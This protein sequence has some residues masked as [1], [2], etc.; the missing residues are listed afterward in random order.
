MSLLICPEC[1]IENPLDAEICSACQ[2]RLADV[3]PV[4]P[5]QPQPADQDEKDLLPQADGD[6]KDLQPQADEDEKD[7]L[8]QADEDLPALLHSLKQD[9]DLNGF[10]A[11]ESEDLPPS[12]PEL[13]ELEGDDDA[14]D[15]PDLPEWLHRIRERAQAETDSMGEITQRIRAARESL[16]DDNQETRH[17]AYES[18]IQ[19]IHGEDEEQ[20]AEK[21]VVEET[22][23]EEEA[24][25][26]TK[27][28]GET[29]DTDW[30]TKIRKKLQP[31]SAEEIEAEP[32]GD[33]LFSRDGDSLLQWLVAL[34]EDEARSEEVSPEDSTRLDT[35]GGDT[36]EVEVS[37]ETEAMAT[38]E[39]PVG[40]RGFT[41]EKAPSLTISQEEQN[42]AD[43]LADTISD[44]KAPR[45]LHQ[46]LKGF[47]PWGIRL[48]MGVLLVAVV[49][50]A[51]FLPAPVDFPPALQG[52]HSLAVLEWTQS[53]PQEASLLFVLD[54]QAGFSAE[55]DLI[56]KPV[57]DSLFIDG[58]EI[59]ILASSPSGSLLF[60]RF[61]EET[62]LTDRTEVIDLGYYPVESFGAYGL[63]SQILSEWR[64]ISQPAFTKTLPS[65][66]LDGIIILAD[67]YEGAMAWVEQLSSLVPE[68]PIFLL[69][70]S[71][72]APLL[73]PYWESGQVMGI[74]AGMPDAVNLA[75]ETVTLT[76]RWRAYQAGILLVIVMLLIG[77]TFPVHTKEDEEGRNGQ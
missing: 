5:E 38:Q 20:P 24:P 14:G 8:P 67:D 40:A 35:P 75:G 2:A 22:P 66:P 43:Q 13:G 36:Q 55:L 76:S 45:S 26:A 52:P 30:L 4:V 74:A 70:T 34:E 48:V 41:K 49:C 61:L 16:D 1:G 10:P 60:S 57:L 7:L 15:E 51:L 56:S 33:K 64:I 73:L 72:A 3:S 39:I 17:Q 25:S 47:S 54:Y 19:N 59:S 62:G 42:R 44:E 71:Q 6:D 29:E 37:S 23:D 12:P 18:V 21:D 31:E 28:T 53:L 68:T 27:D 50:F 9:E 46:R 69:V 58:R 32:V 77:I 65:G 11:D 63:A